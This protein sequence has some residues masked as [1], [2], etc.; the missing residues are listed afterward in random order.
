MK[1]VHPHAE[2]GASPA[3]A[4]VGT[5][6]Y[7][8]DDDGVID[9]PEAEAQAVADALAEAYDVPASGLVYKE[10]GPPDACEVTKQ[11][12]EVCGRERPCPYHD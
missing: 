2:R 8:V 10:D 12:G 1:V 9:C 7:G 11:D 4:T 3:A 6:T 5:E